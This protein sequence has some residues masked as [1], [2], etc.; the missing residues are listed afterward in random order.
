M[1]DNIVQQEIFNPSRECALPP[2]TDMEDA[3]S[4]TVPE[5]LGGR[6]GGASAMSAGSD[7]R[8]DA[9]HPV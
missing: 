3:A 6:R 1:R 4:P 5:R 2:S 8:A 9:R 7:A